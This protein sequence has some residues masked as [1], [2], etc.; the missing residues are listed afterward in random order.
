MLTQGRD[1]RTGRSVWQ[2]RR[3]AAFRTD[4]LDKGERPDAVVVGTGI[5]GALMADALMNCE[6]NVVAV[7]RRRPMT[8]STPA[9]TALLQFEL[10]T[11]LTALVRKVGRDRAARAWL[12][13]YGAVQALGDR[14]CDLDIAYDF[15]ARSTVYLP[16]NVLD[17]P[18]LKS[19]AIERQRLGLRSE[20]IGRNELRRLTGIARPGAILSPGN[21]EADPVKL[22]A[23]LWRQF[24]ARGGKIISPFDAVGV[25][26]SKSW[27]TVRAADGRHIVAK[28]AVMCTGYELPEFAR[29]KGFKVVST[30][31]IATRPQ[32]KNLWQGRQLVWEAADPYLYLRTT[33]DGRVIAG[34]VDEA[35][36]EDVKR[37][38]LIGEKSA[39][40]AKLAKRIF[41]RVDFEPHFAWTGNFGE[42]ETGMPAIGLVRGYK[43]IYS[44]LG[45]GGNGITFSMLAAQIVSRTIDGIC[46]PDLAV[47]R[48]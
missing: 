3:V 36:A 18:G 12:R 26:E 27:V 25:D 10:D 44:V 39:R 22:T 23:G 32:P 11:P 20:F 4:T 19:E 37:D 16:G 17:V 30:W 48:P 31:A 43:R 47:F 46:D 13:S 24:R 34:G 41:P 29:P 40:I 28:H 8:G 5:S 14:I 33:L 21:A 42:S 15:R 6:L 2:A 1:L 45:F 7:D 35:F 9:S 38:R